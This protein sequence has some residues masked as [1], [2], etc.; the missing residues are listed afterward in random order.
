MD[1]NFENE[2]FKEEELSDLNDK[3]KKTEKIDLPKSLSQENMAD[4]L[5]DKAMWVPDAPK[6]KKKSAKKLI[7]SFVA[8]AAS[9]AIVFTS[10]MLIKPWEK[11]QV[12]PLVDSQP[13]VQ[14]VEPQD[15]SEIEGKFSEYVKNYEKYQS[16]YMVYGAIN[17]AVDGLL[18]GAAIEDA[19]VQE[20]TATQAPQSSATGSELKG[21]GSGDDHGRTNEQVKGVSE[22][23]IIKN[24]GK[25]I[26]AVDP[27]NA[28]WDSYY[29]AIYADKGI[30]K[31]TD[32]NGTPIQ[33]EPKDDALPVL[34]YDCT[35]S[36]IE[37]K[38][39]GK[40]QKVGKI[41][42]AQEDVKDIYH[43]MV[44]E[45][46]V[47]GN[48][49]VALVEC[50][51]RDDIESEHFKSMYS[52]YAIGGQ[53]ITMAVCFDITDKANAKE[54][55]RVYQDGGYISSRLVD[56]Q[57]V[58]LSSYYVDITKD[59]ETVLNGCV[60]EVT[61][62]GGAMS[63]VP[64]D[65]IVI[66]NEV[67]SPSYLV[68]SS[69]NIEDDKTLETRAVLGAGNNVYCTTETLYA[70][71]T[72]YEDAQAGEYIF[73]T[74]T[75]KTNIYKFDIRDGKIN[76]IG[77]GSVYGYALN[78]FS[79]DEYNGYLRIATTTGRWG[80][81]LS[82]QVYVLD[83][84][85]KVVGE[86]TGIAK[87]E[88]IKSVRFTG[89]TGYVVTFEQTDPL[90]VIDLT[91]PQKPEIKGELKIPGFSAYLHPVSETLLLGVGVDG[92]NDG[93]GN[94]MKVSLFDVSDP[95]NPVEADKIEINGMDSADRWMYI[96]SEAF[97]SHKAL[98]WDN[99]EGIMYIPYGKQN[100]IWASSTGETLSRTNE[101]GILAVKVNIQDKKLSTDGNYAYKSKDD[102][103]ALHSVY[104]FSRATYIGD[105]II[106]YCY[107]EC[108][109]TFK[110]GNESYVD[111]YK[112]N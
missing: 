84:D 47:K 5:I 71:S 108:I 104:E 102:P 7:Y 52:S 65:C 91:D 101:A 98:C 44:R 62:R 1:N 99:T 20:N 23:D 41:T 29:D 70:A 34:K 11:E 6:G 54:I 87:G 4:A 89:N 22:A 68:A 35:I 67:N 37:P 16:R 94:G 85:L 2:I 53:S 45:M 81:E 51:A 9:F 57:L 10:I 58:M 82:N 28:D 50:Y 8:M 26:Y 63:R 60:P 112:F 95:A 111:M 15:Y 46:Y 103:E 19:V 90:F 59:E 18:G 78:Q 73:G 77:C 80:D 17:G 110:K 40:L 25:Y 107:G 24:D 33:E 38:S 61:A 21:S 32:E 109:C 76:Y 48:K 106:G 83:K 14:A 36:V 49:L 92:T 74:A 56:N 55:W 79:I 75:E 13:P 72:V 12:P 86:I 69:V 3:L 42:I 100:R 93:Q 30:V 97:Y 64:C 27:D 43:M 88:T 39:D 66:G 31:T 105:V 96:Y